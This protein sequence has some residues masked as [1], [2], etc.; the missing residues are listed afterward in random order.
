ML[1]MPGSVLIDIC[2]AIEEDETAKEKAA[3][4]MVPIPPPFSRTMSKILMYI[5][6][7]EVR[8]WALNE[9]KGIMHDDDNTE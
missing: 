7:T 8:R 9:M 3:E 6:D 5:S 1:M 4:I 2:K